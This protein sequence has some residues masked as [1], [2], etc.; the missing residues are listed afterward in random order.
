MI[1][2]KL[3]YIG[4]IM[5]FLSEIIVVLLIRRSLF[6]LIHYRCKHCY[7]T[8]AELSHDRLN[9]EQ[10]GF[11]QLTD[12]EKREMIYYHHPNEADVFVI[13]ES[14]ES[15]LYHYPNYRELEFFIH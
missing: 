9:L 3:S 11:N 14:C 5:T 10:L 6:V 1:I 15:A 4:C 8:I 12:E 7:T 2:E 13:C